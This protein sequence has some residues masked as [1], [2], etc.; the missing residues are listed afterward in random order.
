MVTVWRRAF[1]LHGGDG[2][3]IMGTRAYPAGRPAG[4]QVSGDGGD[5]ADR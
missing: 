5:G 1:R 4:R 2:A 3:G